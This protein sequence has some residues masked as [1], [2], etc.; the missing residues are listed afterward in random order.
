MKGNEFNPGCGCGCGS[1]FLGLV[2]FIVIG[3]AGHGH[4]SD[5]LGIFGVALVVV[6]FIGV[7][8]SPMVYEYHE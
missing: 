2:G 8:F 4:I 6:G 7:V 1:A 5:D 3:I